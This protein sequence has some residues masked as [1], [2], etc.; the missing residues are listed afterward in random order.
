MFYIFYVIIVNLA[1]FASNNTL[2]TLMSTVSALIIAA[3]SKVVIVTV[4]AVTVF[5]NATAAY[6]PAFR[7]IKKK[8][9]QKTKQKNCDLLGCFQKCHG[10]E[11]GFTVTSE[12]NFKT[13][14]KQ[15]KKPNKT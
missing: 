3:T 5:F 11:K 10:S 8:P 2:L 6:D 12:K 1:T 15:E 9:K 7:F 4:I 13:R 14:K